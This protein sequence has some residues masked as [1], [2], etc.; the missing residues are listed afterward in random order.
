MIARGASGGAELRVS[1]TIAVVDAMLRSVRRVLGGDLLTLV[2][3]TVVVVPGAVA[4]ILARRPWRQPGGGTLAAVVSWARLVLAVPTFALEDC[5]DWWGCAWLRPSAMR[6]RD[7]SN[8]SFLPA[9][10]HRAGTR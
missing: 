8:H 2:A 9:T 7:P 5:G 10:A 6:S 4:G 3:R 1:S